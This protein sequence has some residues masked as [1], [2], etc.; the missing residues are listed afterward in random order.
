MNEALHNIEVTGIS[1]TKGD[2]ELFSDFNFSFI[3]GNNYHITGEN[4]SGK[5]SFLKIL[6]GLAQIENGSILWNKKNIEDHPESYRQNLLYIGHKNAV[7]GELTVLENLVFFSKLQGTNDTIDLLDIIDKCELSGYE[8]ISCKY[9]S[10]GQTRR[11][12]IAKLFI[13]NAKIWLLDEPINGLDVNGI[14]VFCNRVNHH[15]SE[16]GITIFTS[17]QS[18]DLMNQLQVHLGS[19]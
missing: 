6:S 2:N 7:K 1:C 4:G 13:G 15:T 11:V 17:H 9:L 10:L 16:G 8:N 12:A 14:E 5:T 3:S 19:T 18:L